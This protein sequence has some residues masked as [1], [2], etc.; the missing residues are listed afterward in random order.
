MGMFVV[1]LLGWS[2][3]RS[4]GSH[5]HFGEEKSDL[6]STLVQNTV[7]R[8]GTKE[9]GE[10]FGI[11]T[12]FES[13]ARVD[14]ILLVEGDREV[15][16]DWKDGKCHQLKWQISGGSTFQGDSRN[17]VLAMLSQMFQRHPTTEDEC[18]AGWNLEC[19]ASFR[20]ETTKLQHPACGPRWNLGS[21][22]E[23]AVFRSWWPYH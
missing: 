16:D 11:W 12:C 23:G 22:I 3:A 20:M 8:I 14:H 13:R 21:D 9:V 6:S 5:G 18:T 15:T 4:V 10:M 1:G 7:G 19:W 17:E 2:Q